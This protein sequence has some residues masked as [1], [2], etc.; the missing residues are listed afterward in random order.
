LSAVTF[1]G[2]RL[3]EGQ[4]LFGADLARHRAA[5]RYALEAARGARVLDL[6]CGTG[7]GSAEL[8]EVASFLVALDRITPGRALRRGSLRYVRAD[9]QH[10]PLATA[11]FD[12]IVSFQVIEHLEDPGPYLDAIAA[13]MAPGATALLTTPNL[14][15][16]D[17][18]NPYHVHE[19]EA[20]ELRE[21]LE[22]QFRS[23]EIKGVGA[24]ARAAR[25]HQA[26][27]R[28]IRLI[29]G[30]DPL[31]IR[32]QLPRPLVEWLF[33]RLAVL[34]RRGIQK[35]GGLPQLTVDDFPVGP[36]D[37]HCLDLLAVCREPRGYSR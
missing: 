14:L 36:A 9:L 18:Q 20:A 37:A 27:L 17:R 1:T 29:V 5:Y 31:R 7:Y 24:S 22:R 34:V 6:G 23:V 26:R 35:R 13:L 4:A 21:R 8:V 30:L 2:E 12:L 16:S 25:Y 3:D 28:R 15:Q 10:I 11:S 19:Y 32:D 33:A